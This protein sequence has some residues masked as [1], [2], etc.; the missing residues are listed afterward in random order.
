MQSELL[1]NSLGYNQTKF[2]NC[3]P[4]HDALTGKGSMSQKNHIGGTKASCNLQ[5]AS[6]KSQLG[7]VDKSS[8]LKMSVCMY[9]LN[10]QI[11]TVSPFEG[12]SVHLIDGFWD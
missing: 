3:R 6:F 8:F 5:D 11:Y 12:L 10:L 4:Q 7:R 9:I 1:T 2:H